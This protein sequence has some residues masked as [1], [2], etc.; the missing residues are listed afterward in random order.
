MDN[1]DAIIWTEGKTD[2]QHLKRA[3]KEL[4]LRKSLTFE[5]HHTDFGD[6]QLLKQ[7]QALARVLQPL[8]TIF[9]FDR[10]K[11]EIV[12]KV[13]DPPNGYKAW[14][15]NV[16]SLA[17]PTPTHRAESAGVCVELF[18]RTR[19]SPP[20]TNLGDGSSCRPSSTRRAVDTLPIHG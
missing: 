6:D 1:A 11:S 5:E 17:I 14:G 2:W 8:P 16:F 3:A 9:V 12:S 13:D 7:C 10:D 20:K 4:Q 19:N 18:I 15:N